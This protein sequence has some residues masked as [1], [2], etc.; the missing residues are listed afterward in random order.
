MT[1]MVAENYIVRIGNREN[2]CR[3]GFLSDICMCGADQFASAELSQQT[4]FEA[5]DYQHGLIESIIVIHDGHIITQGETMFQVWLYGY[6]H[7]ST[8]VSHPT[9]CLMV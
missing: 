2:P 9:T 1:A 5:A 6:T 7:F 4:L 3:V 8:H